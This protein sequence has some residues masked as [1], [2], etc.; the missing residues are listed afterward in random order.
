MR[1]KERREQRP[2]S[3]LDSQI[4]CLKNHGWPVINGMK[5]PRHVL[6]ENHTREFNSV[7]E[8]ILSQ[9]AAQSGSILS[10]P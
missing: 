9:A 1:V 8:I 10:S 2:L 6:Q 3:A 5:Q 4:G 7:L